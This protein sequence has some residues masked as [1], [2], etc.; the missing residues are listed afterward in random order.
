MSHTTPTVV[1]DSGASVIPKEEIKEKV[2]QTNEGNDDAN[3]RE[4]SSSIQD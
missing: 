1:V 3:H 2:V 4:Q